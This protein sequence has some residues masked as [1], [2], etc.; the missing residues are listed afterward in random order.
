MAAT[1]DWQQLIA[2]KRSDREFK[3]HK[4][5]RLPASLLSTI[6]QNSNISV[7]DVP[8]KSGILTERELELTEVYDATELVKMMLQ[9]EVTSYE[10]TLAFCK[11]AAIAQQLVNCLSEIFFDDA[12][13]R[14]RE[15]DEFLKLNGKGM[16]PL[17]GLPIS[18][19]DSFNVKGVHTTIGYV[20]FLSHPP[21][22]HNS[23]LVE[24][25][26]Q[27]GAVLYCK[28]N[29]PQTM[30][31]ADSD[32]NVFGRTLNPNKLSLT[33][34]GSTGGEAALL[35]MRGSVLG[36]ATDIAGSIRIPA[37]CNG[38]IG[39]KPTAGRIPFAGK[40]PPGRLGSPSSIVPVIGPEGHS[41]RD[42]EL[43]MKTVIDSEPWNFD[44]GAIAVPW[45][46]IA[47]IARRLKFAIIEKDPKFPLHPP[48]QRAMHHA[49]DAL[50]KAGH[51]MTVLDDMMIYDSAVLAWKFFLL[52][53]KKTPVGFINA[54]GEP[55][56]PSIETCTF[57]ELADWK[58]TLDD[59]FDMNVQRRR[60]MKRYHDLMVRFEF[61]AILM[62]AYQAT[63]VPHDT[64]GVPIYTVLANLLDYPAAC[65]P[66]SKA[67]KDQ[68]K[69]S[70]MDDVT[71]VP[72][73]VA[74]AVEGMPCAIQL[75]GKPMKDEELL[76]IMEVVQKVL[77]T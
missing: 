11:R 53:P 70:V 33:A 63:A 28:T 42:M 20:S 7:L 45:R 13:N 75:M 35:K 41:I 31:S 12:L 26:F 47:P 49:M 27:Q 5:W 64:Y 44:E 24:I 77:E 14:A 51:H 23:A 50:A 62:P 34:G 60:I 18:L 58:P 10:L 1:T 3:I 55:W 19:K 36:V 2:D 76:Q 69:N 22:A 57:P 8:R 32:N 71:Y 74:D 21:A 56:V 30:M 52:D 72:P 43:F 6:S 66:F 29:L 68:D 4:E 59:L 40:T 15:C 39:F 25:L 54:S 17:H 9:S 37:L 67:N 38:I 48:I 46:T 16:G 65:L 73:Y 61:D